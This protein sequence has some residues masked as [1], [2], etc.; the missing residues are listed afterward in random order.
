MNRIYIVDDDIAVVKAL[1]N[2]IEDNDLG[3]VVGFST[4]ALEAFED[5]KKY[6]PDI[7]LVDFLM[8]KIEGIE[9]VKRLKEISMDIKFI[10][11]SQVSSKDM[12]SKAYNSG[13]EFFINKPINFIEIER[14]MKNVTESI[15]MRR[16]LLA[17][18]KLFNREKNSNLGDI[19]LEDE[20]VY[21]KSILSRLGIIGE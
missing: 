2:I 21:I 4:D 6:L 20:T 16:K 3:D 19:R 18:E 1:E 12:I 5:I 17:I 14:V 8:P 9:L 11:I 13:I 10:M 15:E 7:V